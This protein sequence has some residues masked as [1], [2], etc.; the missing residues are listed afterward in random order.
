[1]YLYIYYSRRWRAAA[2]SSDAKEHKKWSNVRMS[3]I[4]RMQRDKG[5]VRDPRP[6][7]GVPDKQHSQL[8]TKIEKV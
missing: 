7:R 4:A 6:P 2:N 5:S 8:P 3:M 1:M